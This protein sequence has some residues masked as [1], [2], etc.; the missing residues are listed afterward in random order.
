MEN[1][2]VFEKIAKANGVTRKERNET[3][4]LKAKFWLA[5]DAL[6]VMLNETHMFY[7]WDS[8]KLNQ[9]KR[10]VDSSLLECS[11]N[12]LSRLWAVSEW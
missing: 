4:R 1:V 2:K 10:N 9:I 7:L 6:H 12:G 8:Q 11:E 3:F 5:F